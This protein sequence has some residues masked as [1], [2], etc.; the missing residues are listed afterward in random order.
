M[1]LG[2]K[3]SF[4]CLTSFQFIFIQKIMPKVQKCKPILVNKI[5]FKLNPLQHHI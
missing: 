3:G 5:K 4:K 1:F 2:G